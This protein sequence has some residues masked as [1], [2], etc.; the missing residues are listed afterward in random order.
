MDELKKIYEIYWER[1]VYRN[2]GDVC[3]D[4]TVYEGRFLTQETYVYAV[5]LEHADVATL[6]H[7]LSKLLNCSHRRLAKLYY[8][9][10]T[11]EY[12][13]IFTEKITPLSQKDL[14]ENFSTKTSLIAKKNAI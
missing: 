12:M 5:R 14:K 8:Y 3:Y 11:T 4:H 10:K 1:V 6:E 9:T 13:L 2:E 7:K